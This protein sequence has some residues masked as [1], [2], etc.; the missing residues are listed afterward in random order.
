MTDTTNRAVTQQFYEALETSDV[1]TFL[2]I[3]HDD[4]AY[5]V[6]GRTPVSG[7][8]EGKA[9]LVE[10][11]MP[12]VFGNLQMETFQFSKQWKIM[13]ADEN[14]VVAFM[15]A[16][17]LAKNGERY[18]QFYCHLFEFREGKIAAVWEFFDSALAQRALFSNP[19]TQ[20]ETPP[21]T[22]FNF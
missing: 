16:D 22:P 17:G 2:A 6:N 19:L 1:E 14:T 8:F 20:D 5:N 13:C 9:F 3:Q 21:V 15:E 11:V 10:K 4:V 7:R 18:N 12:L